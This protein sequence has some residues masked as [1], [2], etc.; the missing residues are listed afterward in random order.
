MKDEKKSEKKNVTGIT[1]M[2]QVLQSVGPGFSECANK[3]LRVVRDRVRV[4]LDF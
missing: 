2:T 4:Q 1:G 3:W